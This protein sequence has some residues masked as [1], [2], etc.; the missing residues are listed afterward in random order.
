MYQSYRIYFR[1][2]HTELDSIKISGAII[3]ALITMHPGMA[4]E[5]L[6]D[7]MDGS[8]AVS[9]AF[10]VLESSDAEL[11]PSPALAY[12]YPFGMDRREIPVQSAERK[13]RIEFSTLRNIR[14]ICSEYAGKGDN[15]LTRKA[16]NEILAAGIPAANDGIG[17]EEFNEYGVHIP[18]G[19]DTEVYVRELDI[20]GHLSYR[21]GKGIASDPVW[22]VMQYS[23]EV[24]K[25]AIPFLGDRG[26]S[27]MVSRG[28][29]AFY[30]EV[31]ECTFEPGFSGEGYYLLLAPMIPL[32]R[33]MP[34][35]DLDRSSYG[36]GI[37]S[38]RNRDGSGIGKYRYF[39]AGS[40]L[41]LR[42]DVRGRVIR[43][44]SDRVVVFKAIAVK[45]A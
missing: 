36:I 24:F 43:A 8:F 12:D 26:I 22:F 7:A 34:N 37:F 21:P 30:H 41:Y 42:G 16:A 14:R 4:E 20:R 11:F 13:R 28:K 23:N 29:G 2:A 19:G 45:V 38:G 6:K 39:T 3:D 15:Q 17:N 33:E 27:G 32:E 40:L 44:A 10:P 9:S 1:S 18:D 31:R 35:V 25:D 5:I